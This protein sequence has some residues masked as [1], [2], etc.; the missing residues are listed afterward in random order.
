VGAITADKLKEGV[1]N[2]TVN[3]VLAVLRSVLRKA[4]YEWKKLEPAEGFEPPT[5]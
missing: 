5:A 2:A 1:A 3:R 4:A